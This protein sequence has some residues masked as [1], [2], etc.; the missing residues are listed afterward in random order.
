MTSR[1]TASA[2]WTWGA[3]VQCVRHLVSRAVRWARWR[4][5][6]ERGKVRRATLECLDAASKG[7]PARP[8]A[9]ATAVLGRVAAE[10][11]A[12]AARPHRRAS[13]RAGTGAV[14]HLYD[15]LIANPSM[16]MEATVMDW[17]ILLAAFLTARVRS[18][19][20]TA[21]PWV[22]PSKWK[23][24]TSPRAAATVVNSAVS[25][26]QR[27]GWMP[28]AALPTLRRQMR[29]LGCKEMEDVR[30][31]EP[32]FG[33]EITNA[34]R[35]ARAPASAWD[36]CAWALV[37]LGIVGG[38][39]IGSASGLRKDCVIAGPTPDVVVVKV[40]RLM[41]Q[42]TAH[43]GAQRRLS[44]KVFV[45]QHW[46]IERFVT[47][48]IRWHSGVAKSAGSA[49]FFP[50]LVENR[51]ARRKSAVGQLVGDLWLE[52]TSAWS[53]RAVKAALELV[54]GKGGLRDRSF[55]GLRSGN[56]RELRKCRKAVEDVTRRTLHARSVRDL[57]GSED[58]YADVLVEDMCDATRLIGKH[59]F[60]RVEGMFTVTHVSASSG[61][62]DDWEPTSQAS[63]AA[64]AASLDSESDS[65]GSSSEDTSDASSVASSAMS[66]DCL[67][68]NDHVARQEHGWRCDV[69]SCHRGRCV[70]CHE[71]GRSATMVC[72]AHPK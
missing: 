16:L 45:L 40:R 60:A 52:P 50:S 5:T 70:D 53:P 56:N 24:G 6:P 69:A 29:D 65:A 1:S 47:P 38:S 49:L 3:A 61:E 31:H 41:K 67:G 68:C 72:P 32:I 4:P 30:H 64:W 18:Q 33:F 9:A 23:K 28:L 71:G 15:F 19:A 35:R 10:H 13:D 54:L 7:R 42:Q 58:A 44:P 62:Q 8:S 63:W 25:R 22:R 39:R 59:Q 27:L 51:W 36:R 26:L 17:D 55:H 66:F 46:L 12:A 21:A 48:W 34:A 20:S 11:L 2:T 57:I 14:T 43:A 37:S